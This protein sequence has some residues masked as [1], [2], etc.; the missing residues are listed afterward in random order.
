MNA[1]QGDIETRLE[2]EVSRMVGNRLLGW[3]IASLWV[4]A[5]F[6][7]FR[8]FRDYPPALDHWLLWISPLM[9]VRGIAAVVIHR[10]IGAGQFVFPSMARMGRMALLFGISD[11]LLLLTALVIL[12]GDADA[13]TLI[14]ASVAVLGLISVVYAL[15]PGVILAAYTVVA[16]PA[17]TG[18]WL[19][20][21]E[22]PVELLFLGGAILAATLIG[23]LRFRRQFLR[24][25]G[26]R[27]RVESRVDE[28]TESNY[29]FDQHWQQTALACIDLDRDFII[30]SWNPAAAALFGYSH[31]EALGE[32][33]EM[34]VP[35][36]EAE[37]M[38]RDWLSPSGEAR[39]GPVV[40]RARDSSGQALGTW[41][42]ETVLTLDGEFIG[43]AAFIVGNEDALALTGDRQNQTANK[44]D[45]S[46]REAACENETAG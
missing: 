27:L 31:S 11:G 33:L 42:Y 28:V 19:S 16:L 46:R 2:G 18:A 6:V 20:G 23:V 14:L 40:R 1:L 7:L 37:A 10:E 39:R 29:I 22:L 8:L 38:R 26:N 21:L 13:A 24:Q 34:L 36:E 44:K 43:I 5:I 35:A 32:P 30:R 25:L 15:T 4:A 3:A 41:W 9:I 12:A 45:A 17:V